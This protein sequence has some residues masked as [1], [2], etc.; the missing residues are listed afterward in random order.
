MAL[1]AWS[2]HGAP[3]AL[4]PGHL[5]DLE[6]LDDIPFLDVVEVL[7]RDAALEACRDLTGVLLETAKGGDP[8]GVD[9]G[10]V[11]HQA[12]PGPSHDL[13]FRHVRPG[14]GG[15]RDLEDGAHLHRAEQHLLL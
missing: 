11:A 9:H 1:P 7:E 6:G 2:L 15:P 13:A 12:C 3:P 5:A 4:V 14:H 10:T 8:A